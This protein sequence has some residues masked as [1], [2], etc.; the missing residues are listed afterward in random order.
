M[1]YGLPS[2]P[3]KTKRRN[4][5]LNKK[6]NG[7]LDRSPEFDHAERR[8]NAATGRSINLD[9]QDQDSKPLSG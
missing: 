6:L 5:N 9:N 2:F 8:N 4:I 3:D 1:T 7:H